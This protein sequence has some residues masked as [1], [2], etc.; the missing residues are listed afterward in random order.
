MASEIGI[1]QPQHRGVR[2]Q[3]AGNYQF[4]YGGHAGA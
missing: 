2:S 1:S 4:P 3:P